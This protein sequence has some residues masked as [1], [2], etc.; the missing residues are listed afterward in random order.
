MLSVINTYKTDKIETRCNKS[1]NKNSHKDTISLFIEIVDSNLTD[2][3]I[4]IIS[5]IQRF[6]IRRNDAEYKDNRILTL[7]NYRKI[8]KDDF[9]K[10]LEV[11][12]K[13]LEEEN[14]EEDNWFY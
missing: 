10:V 4:A 9:E 5:N 13:L 1:N 2:R 12:N 3:E 6:R 14:H 7:D 8:F 11:M